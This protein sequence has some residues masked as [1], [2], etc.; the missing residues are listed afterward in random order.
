MLFMIRLTPYHIYIAQQS[1]LSRHNIK[2]YIFLLYML[3]NALTAFP[4]CNKSHIS[5]ARELHRWPCQKSKHRTK[6]CFLLDLQY[7]HEF[8]SWV[9]KTDTVLLF[10][11]FVLSIICILYIERCRIILI[12][13][14]FFTYQKLLF[15]PFDSFLY[16]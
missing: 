16:N 10:T 12:H 13:Q 5:S 2:N 4:N 15:F 11:N 7:F 14:F 9:L 6:R 8:V 1:N 3:K